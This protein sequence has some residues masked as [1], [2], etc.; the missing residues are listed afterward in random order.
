MNINIANSSIPTKADATGNNSTNKATS[1]TL[2][3]ESIKESDGH[4]QCEQS[5]K[6]SF[7]QLQELTAKMTDMMSVMRKGLAFRIDDVS[8][9]Q[10]VSVLDEGS[11]ELIRQIPTEEALELAEKMAEVSGLLMKAKA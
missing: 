3:S 9:Q 2:A 1:N 7:E 6:P 11:G 10:V 4:S 5:Q 8:G